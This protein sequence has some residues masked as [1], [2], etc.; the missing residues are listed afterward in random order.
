MEDLV[1]YIWK[2]RLFPL[3]TLLTTDGQEVEVVHPGMENRNDGP[4]FFNA[5]V[6]IGG[7]LWVGN[8]EIHGKASDWMLHG[9]ETNKRYDSVVLHVVADADREVVRT[10]GT[11]IPQLVLPVPEHVISNY[12]ELCKTDHYPPCYRVIP[13]LSNLT[14]HSYMS[15][16]QRLLNFD[17]DF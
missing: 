6:K 16:L 9:H 3:T 12:N 15:S 5:K 8:V 2:H 7:T 10:D 17:M 14:I 13:K 11:P 1:R 4:D